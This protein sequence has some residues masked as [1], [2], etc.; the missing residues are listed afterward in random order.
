M[1]ALVQEQSLKTVLD[2]GILHKTYYDYMKA[3]N[4]IHTVNL[5][6][7]TVQVQKYIPSSI[8][9]INSSMKIRIIWKFIH[10]LPSITNWMK[11]LLV[12]T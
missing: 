11:D 3:G 12:I 8:T 5:L 1:K 7:I 2:S 6:A 9:Q 10:S 4:P